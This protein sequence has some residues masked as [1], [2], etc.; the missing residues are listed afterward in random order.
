MSENDLE[1]LTLLSLL[2]WYWGVHCCFFFMQYWRWNLGLGAC[3]TDAL[4]EKPHVQALACTLLCL[5]SMTVCV[6]VFMTVCV[7][8]C[9]WGALTGFDSA[10]TPQ[11]STE[12]F[13]NL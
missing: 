13:V 7:C 3:R 1:V 5:D 12:P 6:C 10:L 8:V 2:P 11:S 4:P 9:M